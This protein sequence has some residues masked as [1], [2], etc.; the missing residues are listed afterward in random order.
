MTK[1]T[2]VILISLMLTVPCCAAQ[3]QVLINEIAW[4]GTTI[5]ANYE[6]LELYNA[7]DSQINLEG[8]RLEAA[9][10][11]PAIN[12]SGVIPGKGYFMLERTSDDTLLEIQADQIFSGSLGNTGEH[13]RLFDETGNIVDQAQF[14][15][16]WGGG[17]NSTKQTLERSSLEIW[18]TSLEVGGTP[19]AK[20]STALEEPEEP[21][22]PECPVCPICPEIPECPAIPECPICPEVPECPITPDCP[23]LPDLNATI[24]VTADQIPSLTDGQ[25]IHLQGKVTK[26]PIFF[27]GRLVAI[28]NLTTL[29]LGA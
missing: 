6:W 23:E 14:T 19:K 13:L 20:N 18:A 9:D 28:D 27:F 3:A 29:I 11:T 26:R 17:D 12:L 16:G 8:W 25:K 22:I 7:T 10:G 21:V 15:D 24:D 4:M 5:S 2:I 1:L